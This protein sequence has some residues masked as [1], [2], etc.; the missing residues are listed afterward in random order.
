MVSNKFTNNVKYKRKVDLYIPKNIDI[1]KLLDRKL[2]VKFIL[3][4]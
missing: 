4:E 1:E 3:Y 2:A